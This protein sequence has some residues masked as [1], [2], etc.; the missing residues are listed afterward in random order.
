[1]H[2]PD[3]EFPPLI[4]GVAVKAPDRPFDTAVAAAGRGDASAGD[5]YWG[6]NT[7]RLDGAIVL[8]PEVGRARC[9]EMLFVAQV[10]FA[11]SFGALAPPNSALTFRWPTEIRLNGGRIGRI[12]VAIADETD[13]DGVPAWMVIGLDIDI[14]ENAG[15]PDPGTDPDRTCLVEEG[16]GDLDRTALAESFA[17]HLLTWVHAWEE[18]GFRSVTDG[19]LFRAD[20][21]REAIRFGD[22]ADGTEGT[23]MG[24]DEHG[25]L[26]VRTD[27]AV[28]AIDG[29]SAAH[30]TNV[31]EPEA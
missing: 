1:M 30:G 7:A 22:G 23:F 3:P 5:F 19:Y 8:E 17:R 2:L 15:R 10:A 18:D 27:A 16:C 14:S 9:L 24:L 29:W 13:A 28:T 6:R 31:V 26:L 11:E 25:G 20:G 12:S 4:S 21:Y